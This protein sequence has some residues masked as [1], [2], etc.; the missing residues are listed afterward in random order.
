[1][2]AF[3]FKFAKLPFGHVLRGKVFFK[4]KNVIAIQNQDRNCLWQGKGTEFY[5]RV[6]KI[7]H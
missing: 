7:T 5:Q 2:T 3:L 1:M 6:K 4:S